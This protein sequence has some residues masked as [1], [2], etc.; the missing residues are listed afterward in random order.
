MAHTY[1]TT[2]TTSGPTEWLQWCK[3]PTYHQLTSFCLTVVDGCPG[4]GADSAPSNN[5]QFSDASRNMFCIR[6]RIVSL[7][8]AATFLSQQRQGD[9]FSVSRNSIRADKSRGDHITPYEN[10]HELSCFYSHTTETAS[11]RAVSVRLS[12]FDVSRSPRVASG[13]LNV[14][15]H[16]RKQ[17]KAEMAPLLPLDASYMPRAPHR[18][19]IMA[20][21]IVRT[22]PAEYAANSYH[23]CLACASY[24]PDSPER[25]GLSDARSCSTTLIDNQEG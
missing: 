24:A 11:R 16:Y 8:T 7:E 10:S 15:L 12:R 1:W 22:R 21:H 17:G 19:H 18:T 4:A 13:P 23:L 5:H 14:W 6:I 20:V 3:I 9:S 2:W 25:N